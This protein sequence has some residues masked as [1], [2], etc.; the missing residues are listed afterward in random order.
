[1]INYKKE[2]A[3][4]RFEIKRIKERF[5]S[6]VNTIRGNTKFRLGIVIYAIFSL[7]SYLNIE[8]E[9][10]FVSITYKLYFWSI[11]IVVIGAFYLKYS[12]TLQD[13]KYS[14]AFQS[15]GLTNSVGENPIFLYK[16]TSNR[17]VCVKFNPVG[18]P[19]DVWEEKRLHIETI[20]NF[21]IAVIKYGATN[22]EILIQGT[23]GRFD[24]SNIIRWKPEYLLGESII[25]LGEAMGEQVSVDLDIYPHIL[26][27][28]STGSGKTYLLKLMLMQLIQKNYKVYIADFKEGVDFTSIWK[29]K[30]GFVTNLN[31]V[32]EILDSICEELDKRKE[33]FGKLGCRNIMNYNKSLNQEMQRII[34]VCDEVAE[35]TDMTGATKEEKELIKKVQRRLN[36]IARLGRAFGIHMILST[37]RP[38]VDVVSG[39]IKN[40]IPARICGRAEKTLSQIILDNT[41]AAELIDSNIQGMFINQDGTV[42][43]GYIFDERILENN[44]EVVL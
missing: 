30:C 11:Q 25:L 42:F 37:Q 10:V 17:Y 33:V 9:N 2:Q 26:L 3:R 15:I 43:K 35:L 19:L 12:D 16:K 36:T 41:D 34:F 7:I 24:Y 8:N 32:L 21:S 44:K 22:E 1:M 6:L 23:K 20:L 5:N 29:E 28:G 40:N 38:S 31:E 27:G 13:R 4:T 14:R 39:A 18:I